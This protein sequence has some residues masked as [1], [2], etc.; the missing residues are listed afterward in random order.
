MKFEYAPLNVECLFKTDEA[1]KNDDLGIEY[2]YESFCYKK[3]VSFYSIDYIFE[4]KD[5]NVV[6]VTNNTKF[7][8]TLTRQE[9]SDEIIKA[10]TVDV[11]IGKHLLEMD[12]DDDED[13]VIL[14]IPDNNYNITIS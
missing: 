12:V 14:T 13:D 1:Y 3:D 7:A 5:G 8:T 4:T 11:K 9:L 2:D 6:I 10:K